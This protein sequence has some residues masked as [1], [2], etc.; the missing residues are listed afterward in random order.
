MKIIKK[1]FR[2]FKDKAEKVAGAVTAAVTMGAVTLS[3]FA[4]DGSEYV[5]ITTA[6]LDPLLEGAKSNIAVVVPVAIGI[7]AILFGIGLVPVIINKFK[8]G[9]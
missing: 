4:A 1:V 8:Q 3:S 7:F 9:R 2:F 5:A 6:D